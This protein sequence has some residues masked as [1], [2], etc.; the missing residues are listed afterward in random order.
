MIIKNKVYL[1]IKIILVLVT[2]IS[3]ILVGIYIQRGKINKTNLTDY[4]DE[5][6]SN[7]LEYKS[8][9]PPIEYIALSDNK[10]LLNIW[11]ELFIK[12]NEISEDYFNEHIRISSNLEVSVPHGKILEFATNPDLDKYFRVEY[13]FLVDWLNLPMNG[14]FV[15]KYTNSTEY[16][17][18]EEI[19]KIAEGSI[20][21]PWKMDI[22]YIRD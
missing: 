4:C 3:L 19:F 14:G 11:K 1:A 22:D 21:K 15:I 18:K 17:T 9:K 16:L 13:Y 5:I 12:N 10:E 2:I 6:Q 7:T 20:G 8:L